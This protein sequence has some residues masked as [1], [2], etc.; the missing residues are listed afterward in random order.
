V[1]E[2]LFA[3]E[4]F[5]FDEEMIKGSLDEL[6]LVL[7]ALRDQGTHG[8]GLM[9]DL[10]ELFDAPLSPGTV[11]PRLHGMAEADL[12]EVHELVRT[13]EYHLDG[14]ADARERVTSAMRQHL[15]LGLFLGAALDELDEP[16]D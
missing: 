15:T 12:L 14:A 10:T 7:V 8:K 13:K 2:E 3:G 1:L 11:Y 9:E 5:D 16:R 6:L 4:E